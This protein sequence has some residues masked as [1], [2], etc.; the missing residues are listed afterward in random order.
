MKLDLDTSSPDP[1]KM[2][3]TVSAKDSLTL[4]QIGDTFPVKT[5]GTIV[6]AIQA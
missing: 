6:S 2:A 3:K 4:P 1:V 5:M